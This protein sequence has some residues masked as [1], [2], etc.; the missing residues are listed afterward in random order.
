MPVAAHR[1]RN[2][3]LVAWRE[4][5]YRRIVEIGVQRAFYSRR[6]L[7]EIPDCHWWGVDPW[8]PYPNRSVTEKRQETYYQR[9]LDALRKWLDED[10]ATILRM[11][12]MQ[13]VGNFEDGSLDA[14]Y[15]DGDHM[16]DDK[17]GGSIEGVMLDLIHWSYKVRPGGMV[18]C[19]DY[20]AMRKGGVIEAVDA[21]TRAHNIQPWFVTRE[22]LPTAFWLKT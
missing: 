15:I 13:A 12:S 19:H 18:A 16:F 7:T 1:D 14:V 9:T 2:A 20:N 11:G 8:I 5:K 4:M 22:T 21:Y 17:V 10:R 3:L 6:I